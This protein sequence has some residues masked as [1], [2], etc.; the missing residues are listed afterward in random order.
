MLT[1]KDLYEMK[2]LE[3]LDA[4][5]LRGCYYDHVPEAGDYPR[6]Q[7]ASRVRVDVVGYIRF[8]PERFWRLATVWFDAKPVMVIQNVGRGGNDYSKRFVTD[9][10]LYLET[11]DYLKEKQEP[12]IVGAVPLSYAGDDLVKFYGASLDDALSND[13]KKE[14]V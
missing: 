1:P 11:A 5:A 4:W 8:D 10:P 2:S 9:V 6:L 14:V 13:K 3:T 12:E 7:E